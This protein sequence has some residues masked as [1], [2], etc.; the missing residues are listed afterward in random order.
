MSKVKRG[1]YTL[2]FKIGAVRLVRSGGNGDAGG[3]GAYA[4]PMR[5]EQRWFADQ[6]KRAA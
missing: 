6:D 2:E 1:A 3:V 4:S 5:F